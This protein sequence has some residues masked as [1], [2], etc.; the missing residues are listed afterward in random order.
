MTANDLPLPDSYEGIFLRA[1]A[2]R[3]GGDIAEAIALYRRLVERLGRLNERILARRPDLR[4][5]ELEARHEL[6]R[7]LEFEGRYA[8]AGEVIE[9]LLTTHPDQADQWRRQLARL[10]I[11]RGNA[12]EGLAALRTLAEEKPDDIWRWIIL[13]LEA[14]F[15]GRF[16]ESQAALDRAL[17]AGSNGDPKALAFAHY[18][19]F[20]LYKEMGRIDDALLA[21]E[22]A[23]ALD[24]TANSV[25]QQVYT[26]LTE[27]GRYREALRY[28][29]RDPNKLQAGFQRGVIARL[30]G[31]PVQA[32]QEWQAVAAMDPTSFDY[33]YESW[34]EA[35]LRVG[36]PNPVLQRLPHLVVRYL[37]PRLLVLTGI[38]WAMKGNAR[39]AAAYLQ[40]AIDL[41]RRDRPPKQKLSAADWRLLDSLV[42]SGRVKTALK[43]YFAVLETPWDTSA[44]RSRADEGPGLPLL[45][46]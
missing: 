17:Q 34:M 38:A 29:E 14:R 39:R 42:A 21:W 3:Q 20:A 9:V 13:G 41:L 10:S 22:E 15:E 37:T 5:L 23:N 43:P 32:R 27:A 28:V 7:L 1:Q 18:Q 25:I 24:A 35:V 46:A 8:E 12:E 44:S 31:D 30:M 33:G 36:D 16:A 4:D 2:A 26:M 45:P 19:R 11:V 40:Q 6:A